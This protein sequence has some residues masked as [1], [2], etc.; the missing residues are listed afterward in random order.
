MQQSLGHAQRSIQ[1]CVRNATNAA[2]SRGEPVCVVKA[3]P[4]TS[5]TLSV[6]PTGEPVMMVELASASASNAEEV[7]GVADHDIAAA[8]AAD[9]FDGGFGTVT[10]FGMA[11]IKVDGSGVA[12]GDAITPDVTN[13]DFNKSVSADVATNGIAVGFALEPI[14]A[15]SVGK[16]WVNFIT[17]SNAYT[18]YGGAVT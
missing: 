1:I 6:A 13:D 18:G 9:A 5:T 14:A 3:S 2:I 10:V 17:R 11:D 4:T 16:G 15:S 12:A 7:F 8:T